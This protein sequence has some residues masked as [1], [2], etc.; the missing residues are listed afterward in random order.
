VPA[1]PAKRKTRASRADA[2][3][4]LPET[5][6]IWRRGNIGRLMF[7]GAR[8]FEERIHTTV[9]DAGFSEIRFV[10]LTL[11]RNMN[12]GGTRLT[13]LAS[14]AGM[15]KQ[16]MGQLVDECEALGIIERR[17]DPSDR[18]ARIIAFTQR[19]RKLLEVLHQGI[20]RAEAEMEAAVGKRALAVVRDALRDYDADG[21][22]VDAD[23]AAA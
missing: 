10:H 16:A 6:A 8:R 19:G 17:P 21:R 9:K 4:A 22:D 20:A 23:E 7:N 3:P 13:T 12:A 2:V 15:T 5:E 18:R 11:T 14:R 1:K